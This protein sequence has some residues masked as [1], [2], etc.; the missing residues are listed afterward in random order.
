MAVNRQDGGQGLPWICFAGTCTVAKVAA[1]LQRD[2]IMIE[3]KKEYIDEIAIPK[4]KAV[5]TGVSVKEL[6]Q[7]QGALFDG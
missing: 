6:E 5:E 3:L 7:G 1:Q 4:L 2:Y